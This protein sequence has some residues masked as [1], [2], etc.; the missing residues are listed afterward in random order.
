MPPNFY[1]VHFGIVQVLPVIHDLA[2]DARAG[3]EVV[4]AV[5]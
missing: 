1:R 5:D 4:H 2:L 3:D